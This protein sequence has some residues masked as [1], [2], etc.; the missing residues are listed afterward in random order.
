VSQGGHGAAMWNTTRRLETSNR[1]RSA[2]GRRQIRCII[3]GTAYIQSTRWRSI[4]PS[5]RTA[6]KRSMTTR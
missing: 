1:V 2:S 4:R 5:A 3:V 6:S